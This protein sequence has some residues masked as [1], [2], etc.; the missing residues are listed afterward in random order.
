MR[1]GK[2]L[3]HGRVAHLGPDAA[4]HERLKVRIG[5]QLLRILERR[6]WGGRCRLITRGLDGSCG[7]AIVGQRGCPLVR[8]NLGFV[9]AARALRQ[10]WS[11]VLFLCG[12]ALAAGP[13]TQ[14]T[15]AHAPPPAGPPLR[16]PS[17]L[18]LKG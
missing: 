10:A 7:A 12:L 8:R 16:L 14:K 3:L 13:S 1:V 18:M 4:L 5:G 2:E 6:Q 17:V 9:L 11:A 15:F